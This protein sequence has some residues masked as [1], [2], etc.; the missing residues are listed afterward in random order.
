MQRRCA[1]EQDRMVANDLLENLEHLARF[2]LDDLLGALHRLGDSLLDELVDDERLEQLERHRLRQA[3]LVQ[4]EFRTHDDDR[5]ARVVHALA[6]QV[7]AEPALLALEHVAERLERTLAAAANGL[8]A[9][10]VVEQRVDRL[11]QHALLVPENDLRRAMH[12]ELLQA[13]V[14]VDD[15][16]IEIVQVR[17][18]E[19]AAV[20]RNEGAQVRRNHRDDVQDHP[21]RLVA[22]VAVVAR[23][24]ERVDD[25]EALQLLLLLVLARL[26]DHLRAE[27]VGDLVDVEPAEQVADRGGADVGEERGIALVLRL[28]AQRE[29]LLF[30]E[31]LVG[32]DFLIAGLDDD[33]VRIVDDL[34][35]IAQREV[36]EVA[37]RAGQR[38][39]EPDMGDGNGE[40]DVPHAVA[41][42][43]A[44]GHFDAATVADHAAIADALVL[45]AMAFPVLDGTKNALAE[46]A[47]L[48]GLERPVVDG[49]GFRDFAPRPPRT[50]AGHLEPLTFLGIPGS[51][52]LLR[53]G[54]A[55]LDVVKSGCAGLAR[56]AEIDHVLFL[57]GAE[58]QTAVSTLSVGIHGDV[59]TEGL[60]FLHEHVE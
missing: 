45:A 53:R 12:D 60:Q 3:A 39:E 56:A 42:D 37:H 8:G 13:V 44:Q 43:L 11:L 58:G 18:R 1:V 27:L 48:L 57:A 38:L 35:E 59:D 40:L 25:L 15:A 19:T 24:A 46:E 2:L 21:F 23:V 36:E 54:D 5:T 17:R 26:D 33:V 16:A 55:D 41:T 20:E 7:L 51:A 31:E 32:V 10:T 52:D 9:A 22:H 49:L 28:G 30:V 50:Q 4:L 47:V 6:E 29:V 34:L 14:A